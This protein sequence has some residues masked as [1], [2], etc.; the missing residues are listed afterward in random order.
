[1]VVA[2]R[3]VGVTEVLFGFS[4]NKLD[5]NF[6]FLQRGLTAEDSDGKDA[7]SGFGDEAKKEEREDLPPTTH[8]STFPESESPSVPRIPESSG[9]YGS[10]MPLLGRGGM[11]CCCRVP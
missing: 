8:I 3:L 4:L 9:D 5:L 7:G 11:V 2:P 1:M 10:G 6:S